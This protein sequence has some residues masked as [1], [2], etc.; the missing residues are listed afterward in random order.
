MQSYFINEGGWHL[1]SHGMI[2]P[3]I[4]LGI[5]QVWSGLC[6]KLICKIVLKHFRRNYQ[7]DLNTPDQPLIRIG[8]VT[9][10][11][12]VSGLKFLYDLRRKNV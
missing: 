10:V 8:T 6:L 4:G 1:H 12:T 11:L 2:I 9:R 7:Y 3:G 5:A